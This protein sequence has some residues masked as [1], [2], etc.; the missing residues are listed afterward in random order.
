MHLAGIG[1]LAHFAVDAQFHIQVVGVVQF[2]QGDQ[3]GAQ[4]TGTLEALPHQDHLVG[5]LP[6]LDVPGGQVIED[7]VT[8]HVLEGVIDTDLVGLPA[9]DD[10]DLDLVIQLFREHRYL[11]PGAAGHHGRRRFQEA[12]RVFEV[13]LAPVVGLPFRIVPG[14]QFFQVGVEIAGGMHYLARQRHR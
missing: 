2:I 12:G 4:R 10:G 11:D 13:K 5:V 6:G 8:R 7:G 1:V 14:R 9:D 3:P